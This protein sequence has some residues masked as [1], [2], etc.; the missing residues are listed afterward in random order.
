MK[1]ISLQEAQELIRNGQAGWYAYNANPP[2]LHPEQHVVTAKQRHFLVEQ[3]EFSIKPGGAT[4]INGVPKALWIVSIN[5]DLHPL[6]D[7]LQEE[8]AGAADINLGTDI[9]SKYTGPGCQQP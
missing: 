4:E 7:L 3:G 9:L 2:T 8:V 1:E 5:D 6:I